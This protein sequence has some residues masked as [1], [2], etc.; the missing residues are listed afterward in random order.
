MADRIIEFIRKKDLVLKQELGRG[1]CG[2]TVLLHDDLIDEYF[3]C[4]KYA[5][6][7]DAFRETLFDNFIREIKILHLLNHTNIVRVFN[8]YLYPKQ[9]TGYILMEFVT[10]T[11]IETYLNSHPE[12]ATELF[13]QTIEGFYYLETNNIL[14]RDIRPQNIMVTQTGTVKLIDFGFGKRVFDSQDFDKSITLNWWCDPPSDFRQR[15]YDYKTE[16]YFVGKLFE[17]LIFENELEQFKHRNLL[18]RMCAFE[19]DNRIGSFADVRR[20]ILGEKFFDIGFKNAELKTYRQFSSSLYE[21]V[22][23]IE[24]SAK[25]KE[26]VEDIQSGLE[27]CYKKVMLEVYMPDNTL[28]IRCFIDG[29]YYYS[30]DHVIRVEVLKSFLELFRSCS[31]EKK[32]IILSNLQTKLDSIKRYNDADTPF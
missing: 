10:G 7:N 28:V 9:F 8:Y 12:N 18:G 6:L 20:E 14:H 3:V 32:N 1:A 27:E 23:K 19:A 31:R 2:R 13:A 5:P 29:P 15:V 17:K 26:D 21:S 22:S 30:K 25:Y 11:D 16:V 24:T 4:K